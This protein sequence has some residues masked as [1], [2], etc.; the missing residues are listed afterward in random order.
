MY[1]KIHIQSTSKT[2]KI[3]KIGLTLLW[4]IYHFIPLRFSS[5]SDLICEEEEVVETEHS[6]RNSD[7]GMFCIAQLMY[8]EIKGPWIRTNKKNPILCRKQPMDF[9]IANREITCLYVI[10]LGN[11]CLLILFVTVIIQMTKSLVRQTMKWEHFFLF[12][13]VIS[14]SVRCFMGI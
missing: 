10:G 12:L 6:V 4:I 14:Q 3:Q 1:C 11:L 8:H 13:T 7:G 5:Q 2:T 9:S